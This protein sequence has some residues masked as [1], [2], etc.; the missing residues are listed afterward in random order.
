VQQQTSRNELSIA[1]ARSTVREGKIHLQRYLSDNGPGNFLRAFGS[2][3]PSGV[4][5][6]KRVLGELNDLELYFPDRNYRFQGLDHPE[7][8]VLGTLSQSSVAKDGLTAFGR[9]GEP[10]SLS[11]RAP[12]RPV[13]VLT[14]AETQFDASGLAPRGRPMLDDCPP[15]SFDCGGGSYNP[16][17]YHIALESI[18]L[19]DLGEAWPWG[20]PELVITIWGWDG[21][22]YSRRLYCY[23]EDNSIYNQDGNTWSGP[24]TLMLPADLSAEIAAHGRGPVIQIH[25]NDWSDKCDYDYNDAPTFN[26]LWTITSGLYAIGL[27]FFGGDTGFF[28]QGGENSGG[29]VNISNYDDL[30]GWAGLPSPGTSYPQEV[31]KGSALV[32]S[33]T[34]RQMLW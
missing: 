26:N 29:Q 28:G 31:R 22:S 27:G 20:A 18:S 14:Y 24:L 2:S 15:E 13:L 23:D 7:L 3:F 25:E 4:S 10:V 34:I 9:T 30:I 16:P 1:F 32:G 19:D 21:S 12:N 17:V 33:L 8:L 6:L 5:G 11:L